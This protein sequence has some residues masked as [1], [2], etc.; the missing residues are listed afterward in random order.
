MVEPFCP[1]M[2][3]E[4]S[5]GQLMREHDDS[6]EPTLGSMFIASDGNVG[7]RADPEGMKFEE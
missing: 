2:R 3:K 6:D 5:F 7:F 4:A 1:M